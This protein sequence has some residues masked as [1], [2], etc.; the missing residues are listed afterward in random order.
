MSLIT[1]MRKQTAVYWQ[2]IEEVD[3][4]TGQPTW[5]APVEVPV[6]WEEKMGEVGER[7]YVPILYYTATIYVDRDMGMWDYLMLGN[8]VNWTPADPR[9]TLSWE[10]AA[11]RTLPNLRNTESLRIVTAAPSGLKFGDLNGPG[12]EAITYYSGASTTVGIGGV[13]VVNPGTV[14]PISV[15]VKGKPNDKEEEK[16]DKRGDYSVVISTWDIPK[17]LLIPEPKLQDYFTDTVGVRWNVIGWEMGA[18]RSWWRV[19]ARRGA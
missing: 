1:R 11:F 4:V 16:I 6:R 17:N 15:A 2:L 19:T 12:I 8:L 9:S 5:Q 13:A 3:A 7:R 18:L 10:V 14:T